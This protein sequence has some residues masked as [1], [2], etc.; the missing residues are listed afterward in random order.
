MCNKRDKIKIG[1]LASSFHCFVFTTFILN[2]TGNGRL[3][4]WMLFFVLDFPISL[5][6]LLGWDLM[7]YSWGESDFLEGWKDMTYQSW[8]VFVYGVLGTLWWFFIPSV[9]SKL[10]GGFKISTSYKSDH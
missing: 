9:V 6:N 1:I 5:L 4:V 3:W 10:L 8:P 2:I 7:I